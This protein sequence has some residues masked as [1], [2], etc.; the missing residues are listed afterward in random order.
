MRIHEGLQRIP[1]Q[2]PSLLETHPKTWAPFLQ[3]GSESMGN[4]NGPLEITG[5]EQRVKEQRFIGIE[6]FF[7]LCQ[8][9]L[10]IYLTSM[11][12]KKPHKKG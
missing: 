2:L 12:M 5:T 1:S 8:V 6:F 3:G 9:L 4:L 11:Y 7:Y 10:H